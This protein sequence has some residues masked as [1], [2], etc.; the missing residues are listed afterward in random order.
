MAFI[1]TCVILGPGVPGIP[2]LWLADATSGTEPQHHSN[3]Q[4]WDH[5]SDTSTAFL[6]LY[7]TDETNIKT[8]RKE[9]YVLQIQEM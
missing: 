5:S 8:Q 6:S 3:T 7:A 1:L 4:L 2:Q 9:G